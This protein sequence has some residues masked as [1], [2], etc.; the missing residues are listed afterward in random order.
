MQKTFQ[1]ESQTLSLTPQM[2]LEAELKIENVACIR[3]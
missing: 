3:R 2:I 1:N